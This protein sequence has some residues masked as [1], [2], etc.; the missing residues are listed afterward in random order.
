MKKFILLSLILIILITSLIGCSAKKDA[1]IKEPTEEREIPIEED[2]L[3]E[4]EETS[5]TWP[6]SIEETI[7]IE[8]NEEPITLNY[9]EGRN[10]ITYV[11]EDFIAEEPDSVEG[12]AYRFYANY[13]GIKSENVYLEILIYPEDSEEPDLIAKSGEEVLEN[14]KVHDW[15]I[16]EAK[17]A[18]TGDYIMLG[19]HEDRYFTIS[20]NY[21]P[22]FAEGFVPRANKIIE[23][24]YWTDTNEYLLERN[25]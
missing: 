21:T 2:G 9:F 7:V 22:Q 8:A 18:D 23:H 1:P 14:E 25:K 4:V 15:S 3:P 10:F 19:Q 5:K 11:P 16:K 12:E 6:S 17:N 24:L 20:L 13:E